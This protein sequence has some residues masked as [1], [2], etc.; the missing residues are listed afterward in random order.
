MDISN[1]TL[2][3]GDNLEA[4]RKFPD[5]SIDLI[6][7]DP[8][9]NSKRNY[10]VPFK[11]EKGKQ[12]DVLIK[13]FADTWSWG[14]EAEMAYHELLV[15]I[16]GQIGDTI[17]GLR[18]FLNQTPMMAYLVMMAIR[19]VEMHRLLKNTG[20]LYLHCD[21]TANHYLK[22]ILDAV[23][24]VKNFRNEIIWCY[25][26][27]GRGKKDFP[28]KHDVIL[29]YTKSTTY[30]F[31]TDS[32]RVGY[33]LVSEKSSD[34]FTK[35]DENGRL[36][37][38]VFGSDRKKKYRYYKEDGKVP[39]DWWTDIPKITGNSAKSEHT[40]RTGY[41]TQK[42]IELYKRIIAASSTVGD[43]VLDPFAG[44]GTTAIAAEQL[45]REWIGIDLT[46]L[47][48][49]AV[50]LQIEKFCPQIRN[51][52]T[53]IGTPEDANQAIE[54]ARENKNGFEAWCIAH[55]LKFQSNA[56]KGADGG[57]DGRMKFP[58]GR[59]KG[60]PAFG[61]AVAQVKGGH[62][63]LGDVRDFRTAMNNEE[64]DLGIFVATKPATKKM[65]TEIARAGVYQHPYN[66]ERYPRLQHFQ[67]QDYF[68]E[69][70]PNLPS[71]EK[72]V[73]AK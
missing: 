46:Y 2:I 62:F 19:I 71:R 61:K 21:P 25:T 17:E 33:E 73:L 41:P 12:P 64:A 30:F 24:G 22:I 32:I 49:G 9:F 28:R 43:V 66:S 38:E 31:D 39:Y 4:M 63:T 14:T 20:S 15:N 6:A 16:N 51:K 67:I 69:K 36:Y 5:A 53:I 10:F 54:L 34:S 8:P 13:A 18:K 70:M 68:H 23:F 3:R 48:I 52:I 11:D 55:V 47:A 57:I 26:Q 40:E 45:N 60:K 35:V 58:V 72:I 44:C 56:T 1:R 29:R 50:R 59:I 65:E 27:G 7:T 37:K 42:P